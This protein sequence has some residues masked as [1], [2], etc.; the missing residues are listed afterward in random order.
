MMKK[1][2]ELAED[3]DTH[4]RIAE[5]INPTNITEVQHRRDEL[6]YAFGLLNSLEDKLQ[7]MYDIVS[8]HPDFKTEFKWLPNAMTE[9]GRMIQTERD[10]I[11][12]VRKADR[13]RYAKMFEGHGAGM[14]PAD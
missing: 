3:V 13:K 7:L 5:S 14:T 12:G 11:V 9:W 4:I 8:E 10:L 2:A 1:I 6:S